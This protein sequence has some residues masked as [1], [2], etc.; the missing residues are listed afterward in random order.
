[1]FDMSMLNAAFVN[2]NLIIEPMSPKVYRLEEILIG[3][4]TNKDLWRYKILN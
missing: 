4:V 2:I 1:M 3:T